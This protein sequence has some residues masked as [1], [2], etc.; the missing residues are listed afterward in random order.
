MKYKEIVSAIDALFWKADVAED[1]SFTNTYLSPFADQFYGVDEGTIG[2]DWDIFFSYVHPD[3]LSYVF[4]KIDE[5]IKKRFALISYEYRVIRPDGNQLWVYEK[6]ISNVNSEG[7]VQ[8]FGTTVDITELK[9][10][11]DALIVEKD[12]AQKYFDVAKV[13]M[14]VLNTNRDV[15]HINKKGCEVLG[16][17]EEDIVGKNWCENFLPEEFCEKVEKQIEYLISNSN[18]KIEYHEYPILNSAGE[19]RWIAWNVSVLYSKNGDIEVFLCSG[20]DITERKSLEN[21]L[22]NAKITSEL[23]NRFKSEF[24]TNMT[25]EL[26]TPLNSIICFSDVLY[27]EAYGELNEK[28]RIYTENIHKSGQ[29]LL[30]IINNIL[31]LSAIEARATE[32]N[33]EN[34]LLSDILKEIRRNAIPLA[35]QKNISIDIDTD[36]TILMDAD[37]NKI[38]QIINNLVSNAI[39][40]NS[41]GGSILI[42]ARNIDNEI[43]ISVKDTGIGVPEEE[44]EKLFDPFYQIDGSSSR[45]YGGNGVGLALVKHFVGM[46]NGDVWIESQE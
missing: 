6:A 45:N 35:T 14:L 12:R 39:K 16:Y 40:F 4:Q 29:N 26:R 15:V 17:E 2:C 1:G 19:E 31:D 43:N 46:H 24:L 33:C 36:E 3:D 28:Q 20:Q 32:L 8:I 34:F 41:N 27:N 13:I 37:K 18:K 10:I 44:V 9:N 5:T 42:K 25:H 23:A 7:T 11:N 21:N 38:N 22:L 30:K